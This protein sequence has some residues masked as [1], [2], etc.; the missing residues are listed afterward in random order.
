MNTPDTQTQ[1]RDTEAPKK[2]FLAGIIARLDEAMK[3]AAVKK[4]AQS[5]CCPP[6]KDDGESGK[7]G[8]CC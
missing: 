8:K 7:G 4:S 3:S 2:G 1:Q 5:C 6:N